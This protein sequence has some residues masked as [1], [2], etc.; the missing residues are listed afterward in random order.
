MIWCVAGVAASY[1]S[2]DTASQIPENAYF[3]EDLDKNGIPDL[4]VV[5]QDNYKIPLTE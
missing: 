3:I 1:A 5:L 4:V 2:C